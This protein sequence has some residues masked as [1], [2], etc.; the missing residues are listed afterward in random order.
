MA[1]LSA[2]LR[3]EQE[4]RARRAVTEE[5]V[6]IARE[7]HDVVAHHMSVIV[8]QAVLAPVRL[9]LRPH[10]RPRRAGHDRRH[11]QR[12]HGRD[13]TAAGGLTRGR[14]RRP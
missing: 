14:R 7:L 5:R 4:N 10:H 6:R 2:R 12:G 1:E 8:I 11:R 13:E 9:R 3:R